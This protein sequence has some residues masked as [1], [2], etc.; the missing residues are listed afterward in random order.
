MPVKMNPRNKKLLY[1]VVIYLLTLQIGCSQLDVA[2]NMSDKI[3]R[4]LERITEN[5]FVEMKN[6]TDDY[7]WDT[8]HVILPYTN[9]DEYMKKCK[10]D[11]YTLSWYGNKD[12]KIEYDDSVVLLLFASGHK[13]SVYAEIDREKCP[14]PFVDIVNELGKNKFYID[15]SKFRISKKIN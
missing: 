5:E 14:I 1:L 10:D 8:M 13:V 2:V 15:D 7:D 6:L 3:N 12:V 11:G 4:S 9:L